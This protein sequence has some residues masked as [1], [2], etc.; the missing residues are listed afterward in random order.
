MPAK[1]KAKAT[2][3]GVNEHQAKTR[4]LLALWDMGASKTEVAKGQLTKRIVQKVR[5]QQTIKE[6]L[7]NWNK[8]ERSR[9]PQK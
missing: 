9:S 5:K 1:N 2:A 3:S 6:F 7:T 4:L 8:R